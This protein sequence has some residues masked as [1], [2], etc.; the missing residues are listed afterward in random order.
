MKDMRLNEIVAPDQISD[1]NS[2][3]GRVVPRLINTTLGWVRGWCMEIAL[4]KFILYGR[5]LPWKLR[6][7]RFYL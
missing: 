3:S 6:G 2:E 4:F 1:P 5:L 7:E